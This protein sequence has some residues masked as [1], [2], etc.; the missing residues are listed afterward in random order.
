MASPVRHRRRS[1]A[2]VALLL[3]VVVGVVGAF[4]VIRAAN[5]RTSDIQRIEGLELALTPQDGPAQNYLLIGSDSR[6]NA[7]PNDADFGGIGDVNAVSGRRSDTIMILRQEQDG[8]GA[9]IVSL[10]RDLW[11]NIAGRDSPN[12]I[13]SAYSDGTD[14]LATTITQELGIPIHHV[15]DVDFDGFKDIVDAVGGTELCFLVRD[16][17]QEHRARSTTR[18]PDARRSAVVAVRPEPSLRGVQAT[19]RGAPIRPRDLGR[20]ERQQDFIER[21]AKSMIDKLQSDPFVASE[22]ITAGTSAVRMDPGLDPVAAAGTLRKAFSAGLNKYKLPV[23][24]VHERRQRGAGARSGRRTDPR[25]LPRGRAAATGR[26]VAGRAARGAY[27][28]GRHEGLGH[29]R[30][31]PAGRRR[32]RPLSC[33]R[34]R[35]RG[36]DQARCSTSPMPH[37]PARAGR[38]DSSRRDHQRRGLHRCRCLRVERRGGPCRECRRRRVPVGGREL[39]GAHL[40]HV[41]TDYVFDGTLDRAY[42]EGDATNPQ[43]VYGKSKLA[44]EAR[45]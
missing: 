45:R 40:V 4:G 27:T 16:P 21:T 24:G 1:S 32:G 36:R 44:G 14:V 18:L 41:S 8:N 22:L 9:S 37:R 20:I 38:R 39:V 17:R 10:P 23:V 11:I 35:R 5:A 15:V 26:A 12:R 28:P 29:R 42:R 25:L 2:P 31:R 13:N 19:V 6:E 43:S 34:R 7:D 3:A 30:G 33:R